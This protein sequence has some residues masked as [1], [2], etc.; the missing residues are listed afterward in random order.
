MSKGKLYLIPCPLTDDTLKDV[1]PS[2]V[3]DA[4]L[5]CKFFWVENARTARRFISSLKL[6]IDISTLEF[7]EIPGKSVTNEQLKLGFEKVKN[8]VNAGVISEA[9]CPAVADPGSLVVARAHQLN[10]EVV[11]LVGP[12]SILLA[13]MASGFNGQS[14]TF[15]G[16][17]PIKADEKLAK[18]KSLEKKA[19]S[20][21]QSQIFIETPFRNNGMFKDLLKNLQNNT[22]L[23]V[24]ANINSPTKAYIKTYQIHEWKQIP[25]PELHKIPCIFI[26]G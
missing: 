21:N 10:I 3:I 23:C 20:E 19:I 17:L 9:G 26:I 2:Q 14:F 12:S 4:I 8:G 11:P 5:A 16:Y 7:E 13:L 1:L 25:V 22:K 24:A 6:G 15:N 18:L